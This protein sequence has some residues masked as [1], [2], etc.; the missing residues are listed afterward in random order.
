VDGWMGTGSGGDRCPM[1]WRDRSTGV[2]PTRADSSQLVSK[3]GA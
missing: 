3:K 2:E 1:V